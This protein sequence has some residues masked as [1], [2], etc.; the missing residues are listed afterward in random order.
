MIGAAAMVTGGYFMSS[1][2]EN[3]K[4]LVIQ[5]ESQL[6]DYGIMGAEY[7]PLSVKAYVLRPDE[8]VC[9]ESII[10]TEFE[11]RG[12]KI[13]FNIM[14]HSKV[15]GNV[16]VLLVY[17]RGYHA[18]DR[19]TKTE[20]QVVPGDNGRVMCIIPSM[21]S[22]T[23]EIRFKEPIYWRI[24]ELISIVGITCILIYSL[25]EAY[26]WRVRGDEGEYI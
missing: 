9:G 16:I 13:T 26:K 5:D 3:N 17:Y 18:E 6:D 24:A 20:L 23:V 22:G 4:T 15:P 7:L 12:T 10:V 8:I 19:N 2:V 25:K 1:L 14:N 11:K 21:Y